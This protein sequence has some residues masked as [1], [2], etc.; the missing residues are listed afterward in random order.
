MRMFLAAFFVLLWGF[1]ALASGEK[2][3]LFLDGAR[4]EREII[5]NKGII[6][7]PLPSAM[8]PDS[9]RVKPL[10]NS[11]VRWVE[12]GPAPGNRKYSGQLTSLEERRN[13]LLDRLK[14]LDLREEIFKAA[15]KTQSGRALRKTKSNPDPLGS[16]R[17][18]A[19]YALTQLD[20][21]SA[22][23]R[24]SRNSLAEVEKRIAAL[25]EQSSPGSVA[26][27]G[28]SQ[29]GGTI[30]VAYL[31]SDLKWTPWYDFRLTGDGF[32][33]MALCAKLPAEALNIPT[34]VVPLSLIEPFGTETHPYPVSSG[35]TRIAT[36]RLPLVKE[37]F[38]K[39][40]VPYLS[41]GFDNTS[42]Q[43]LPAG[44]A[45]GYWGGEYIGKATFAGCLPGKSLSLDFGKRH[46]TSP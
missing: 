37:V 46:S 27:I 21:I 26:R 17:S 7:V 15:A 2:R 13:I 14:S 28:L 39:G 10:G 8:L 4:I 19:R 33:E 34:A 6:V 11:T 41:L 24:Q 3:I 42:S 32:T 5:A 36:F 9:F 45:N 18:G 1:P 12:I 16:L 43:N 30:R 44:E 31:V 29:P 38:V 25:A 22:A 20:E 40:A 23:R 35:I